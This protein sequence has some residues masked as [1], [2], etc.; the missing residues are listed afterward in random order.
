MNSLFPDFSFLWPHLLW[1]LV[2]LPVLVGVF[3]AGEKR[4]QA[5][6]TQFISVRLQP[7]LAGNVSVAKR[8]VA[9]LL[10]LTGLALAV[11]ALAG[12]RW[13]T[14]WEEKVE[15]GRDI[16]LA[17]DTS[18][19]MLAQ[20]LKPNR[21]ARA[22]LAAQ[23]LLNQLEGDRVGLIAFA[24]S[25]FLQAPLTAD[26]S[27]IRDSLN[28]L[29]TDI[30]PQ[31]GTNLASAVETAT[32]AFG[33][34]E[35]E[36]RALI[37]FTDGENLE[38]DEAINA[39]ARAGHCRIYTVG[40]GSAEGGL[41]P[42]AKKGG[43]TEFVRDEK[44][45]YVTSRLD[46]KRL[47]EVAEAGGG[48][49]VHLENGPAE[50]QKII[51]EGL[52]TM[53]ERQSDTRFEKQPIERYQWPLA[54]A[55]ACFLTSLLLGERRRVLR[56]VAAAALACCAFLPV[57]AQGGIFDK[58]GKPT[59]AQAPEPAEETTPAKPT[60]PPPALDAVRAAMPE[61]AY[62]QACTAYQSGDFAG[63]AQGFSNALGTGSRPLQAKAAYNLANTLARRGAKLEKKED[64]IQEW[65]NALQHYDRSLEIQPQNEDAKH[66]REVVQNA[67]AALEKQ[68]EQKKDD[69]KKDQD[70][71][72]EQK[73]QE[74][75]DQQKS[76]QDKQ[77]QEKKDGQKDQKDQQAGQD[78]DKDKDKQDGKD[79]DKKDQQKDAE[80][81]EPGKEGDNKES[82]ADPQKDPSGQEKPDQNAQ[83]GDQKPGEE[84]KP[85]KAE[86][87]K[88]EEKK[89]GE[90]KAANAQPIDPK[91]EAEAKEEA[92]EAAANA[93]GR[94]TKK[95]AK[96]M[97]EAVREGRVR[98]LDPRED[99]QK[100]PPRNFKDW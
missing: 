33:K 74:K 47:R 80:K 10:M 42:I 92:E 87:G 29:D 90:V 1:S 70:K 17:I 44:N 3:F 6:L 36:Q 75:K 19:S 69:D 81:K 100:V 99:L 72:D 56:P 84:N 7:R 96:Q 62:N 85:S 66:N 93:E 23:D 43:G 86:S 21:L 67:I 53:T 40:L 52:S 59:P 79:G 65:K 31:G 54:G 89:T 45:Q 18:R 61:A 64:K 58:I 20:D 16:L 22:K 77:D 57:E 48:F 78:K 35:S 71:K 94:M 32:D 50:M 28:E 24:G 4:R 41:L 11:V 88:P 14:R 8:R 13:G 2:A 30:I 51:R 49:Y 73:D 91:K 27:A 38:D 37:L 97:L 46:E 60:P 26:Y 68:E 98:L 76:D 82:K 34:G 63:A 25:A 12:P 55:V 95:D 9:F 15:R 39:L 5:L 83:K